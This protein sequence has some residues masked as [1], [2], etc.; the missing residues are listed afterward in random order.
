MFKSCRLQTL[1]ICHSSKMRGF[2]GSISQ[3]PLLQSIQLCAC[4]WIDLLL[5]DEIFIF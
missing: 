4:F 2:L 1:E 3:F 5:S